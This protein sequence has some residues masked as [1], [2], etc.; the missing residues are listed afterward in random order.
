VPPVKVLNMSNTPKGKNLTVDHDRVPSESL[1]NTENRKSESETGGYTAE[2]S[3][4][5]SN[6]I[7][8]QKHPLSPY[9]S[10]K[11]IPES[12]ELGMPAHI[13]NSSVKANTTSSKFRAKT[14]E[15]KPAKQN[16]PAEIK[17][18][19][20]PEYK[21]LAYVLLPGRNSAKLRETFR[22]T[23]K[24]KGDI[25]RAAREAGYRESTLH[26]LQRI[27]N[28]DGWQ[29]LLEKYFPTVMLFEKESMLLHSSDPK[30]ID[31]SLDRIH[32]LKGNF[33]RKVEI[34]LKPGQD[35]TT[36][37]DDELRDAVNVDSTVVSEGDDKTVS[38]RESSGESQE[39]TLSE[40]IEQAT[41]D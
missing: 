21:H 16:L 35:L 33:T 13:K 24:Y 23:I 27:K 19:L 15:G 6:I 28:S 3:P 14:E 37:S 2:T 40:R 41:S 12:R 30:Y 36:V 34:S 10:K 31:K 38:D 22:L 11:N 25:K 4:R 18:I 20:K 26:N 9:H 39:G 5:N 1:G 7:N 32:K 8:D 29:V 17:N